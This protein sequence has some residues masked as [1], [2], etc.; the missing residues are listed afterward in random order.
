M[1]L[2]FD[3]QLSSFATLCRSFLG[4]SHT[5]WWF[6]SRLPILSAAS[7]SAATCSGVAVG[8]AGSNRA[9]GSSALLLILLL[10]PGVL[11]LVLLEG[12]VAC[13]N[14]SIQCN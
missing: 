13:R 5:W 12:P 3:A 14:G 7:V 2:P 10:V 4:L 11:G 1:P 8:R 9:D 6:C